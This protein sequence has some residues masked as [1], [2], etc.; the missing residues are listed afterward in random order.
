LKCPDRAPRHDPS[1][2][3][4]NIGELIEQRID[5]PSVGGTCAKGGR[6]SRRDRRSLSFSSGVV[7]LRVAWTAVAL[8]IW[9]TVPFGRRN[10]AVAKAGRATLPWLPDRCYLPRNTKFH[11][12]I[13]VL[14]RVQRSPNGSRR[15]GKRRQA[16]D[17]GPDPRRSFC[18]PSKDAVKTGG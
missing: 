11:C 16:V 3:Q 8:V 17:G 1:Q 6:S 10:A 2:N 14:D 13:R 7:T 9:A 12:R 18:R 4:A 5:S 15:A